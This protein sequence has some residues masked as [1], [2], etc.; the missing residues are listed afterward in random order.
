VVVV[1]VLVVTVLGVVVVTPLTAPVVTGSPPL[2]VGAESVSGSAEGLTMG[3]GVAVG[4]GVAIAEAE[5][6]GEVNNLVMKPV[7][8]LKAKNP[9]MARAKIVRRP[10]VNDFMSY[11]IY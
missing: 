6:E 10:A 3:V 5:G 7:V 2:V 8:A 4:A 1:V 11:I 9:M